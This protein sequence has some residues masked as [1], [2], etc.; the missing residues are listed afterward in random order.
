MI[1]FEEMAVSEF[2]SS[3]SYARRL[4]SAD[5]VVKVRKIRFGGLPLI[6][7]SG[8]GS[9]TGA[10]KPRVIRFVEISAFSGIQ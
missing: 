2:G 5:S 1:R 4:S 10:G 3:S 7:T 9:R 8:E 6:L